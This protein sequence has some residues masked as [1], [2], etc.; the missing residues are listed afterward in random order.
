MNGDG[1]LDLVASRGNLIN[2]QLFVINQTPSAGFAA[3]AGSPYT[4][5]PFSGAATVATLVAGQPPVIAVPCINTGPGG[6]MI[7]LFQC[8]K[9]NA[10]PFCILK[11]SFPTCD[12]AGGATFVDLDGN[13]PSLGVTSR[14]ENN[15][16]NIHTP[17][18]SGGFN[19]FVSI[20]DSSI[21]GP[22]AVTPVALDTSGKSGLVVLNYDSTR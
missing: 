20:P 3:A 18:G 10:R 22:I 13:G 17:N 12:G 9:P 14:R 11:G 7:D 5:H 2:D 8:G 21:D 15:S 1:Y 19:P 6:N 4:T 16:L